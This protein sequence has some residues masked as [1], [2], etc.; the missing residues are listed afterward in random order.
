MALGGP[1]QV[2]RRPRGA[3]RGTDARSMRAPAVLAVF[4]ACAVYLAAPSLSA[5][6]PRLSPLRLTPHS[7]PSPIEGTLSGLPA[8]PIKRRLLDLRE[9][10]RIKAVE[11]E[12]YE[13]ALREAVRAMERARGARAAGDANHAGMLER[14][15][16]EWARVA[17]QSTLA[18]IA[19]RASLVAEKAAK[20]LAERAERARTLLEENQ[21]RRGRLEAQ[22]M[23]AEAR[24]P[25]NS[26]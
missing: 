19:E 2:R 20:D 22:R 21:A 24:K 11:P 12:A 15:A 23:Q 17:E 1:R 25:R 9:L 10:A 13:P 26:P 14:V 16:G 18:R 4:V 6:G 7:A 5:H 3:R 8:G